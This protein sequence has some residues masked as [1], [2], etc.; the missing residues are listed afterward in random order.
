MHCT[1]KIIPYLSTDTIYTLSIVRPYQND[2]ITV[3]LCK[4]YTKTIIIF[5]YR[6]I[7]VKV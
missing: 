4:K 2:K 5:L 1:D 3:C 7:S 6:Y